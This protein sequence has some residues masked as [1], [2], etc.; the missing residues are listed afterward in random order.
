MTEPLGSRLVCLRWLVGGRGGG[1]MVE[2]PLAGSPAE[3]A[4][5]LGGET[6][7]EIGAQ[8]GPSLRQLLREQEA[9]RLI[10]YSDHDGVGLCHVAALEKS[11]GFSG[12][13]LHP[14][15]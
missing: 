10:R 12:L 11:L 15:S 2:G 3:E 9:R 14:A 8:Q 7:T 13:F 4:G 6:L 1:W 5:V